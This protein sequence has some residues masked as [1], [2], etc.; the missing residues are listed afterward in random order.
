VLGLFE[1]ARRLQGEDPVAP[2]IDVDLRIKGATF[3]AL[4]QAAQE[5]EGVPFV[6][7]HASHGELR[8]VD[9]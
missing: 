3:D 1:H 7:V 9:E 2:Q 5:F 4:Q 6:A 8:R